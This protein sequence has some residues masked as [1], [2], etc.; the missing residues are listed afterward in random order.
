MEDL[1]EE[2]GKNGR[3]LQDIR[4][5]RPADPPSQMGHGCYGKAYIMM[6]DSRSA[7][8]VKKEFHG[9][10]YDGLSLE[11]TFIHPGL[12]YQLQLN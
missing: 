11:V 10:M 4:I 3:V 7:A 8:D 1:Q 2:C 5:P 12:F 6:S 9:R